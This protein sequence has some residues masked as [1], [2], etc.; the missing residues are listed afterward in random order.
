MSTAREETS[1]ILSGK[2]IA[3]VGRLASI[4]RREAAQLVRRHGAVVVERPDASVH[5]AVVGEEELPLPE[6]E[7][8]EE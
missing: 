3:F 4:S 2:R 7:G 5:L 1:E 6:G 8:L